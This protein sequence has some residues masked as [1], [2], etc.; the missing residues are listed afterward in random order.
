[1]IITSKLVK[2]NSLFALIRI[3][4]HNILESIEHYVHFL[5]ALLFS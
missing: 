3:L 1:M 2:I 5:N 4:L